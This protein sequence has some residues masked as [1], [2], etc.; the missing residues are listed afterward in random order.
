M[1]LINMQLTNKIKLRLLTWCGNQSDIIL[2]NFYLTSAYEM[3][4]FRLTKSGISYE[5]E[6]KISKNDFK[7]DFK[8]GTKH[9]NLESG[10]CLCNHFYFVV[11]DNLI[12]ISE[13]PDYAGLIY[14]KESYDR[15]QII[16]HAKKIHS[17]KFQD[18]KLLC[19]KL[20]N[21]ENNLHNKRRYLMYCISDRNKAITKLQLLLDKNN[22]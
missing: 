5:Y 16:K 19:D 13:V 2:P 17:R 14:Y 9:I 21:R 11:P 10:R 20:A 6:I 8:K 3:D 4:V 15:L 18:Y 12:N 7:N 22:I 1:I